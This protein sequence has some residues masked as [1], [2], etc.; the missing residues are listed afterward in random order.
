MLSQK[1]F[2]SNLKRMLVGLR[3]DPRSN[4]CGRCYSTDTDN[5]EKRWKIYTRTGDKG[6][7]SLFTGE[8]RAKDDI[9]F[10]ALGTTDE[11]SSALGLA[12]YYC[13]QAHNGLHESLEEAQCRLQEIG[14][15]IATPRTDAP[16]AHL[17]RWLGQFKP[18]HGS[19]H[20]PTC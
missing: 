11:L 15:N 18:A 7:S 17:R 13:K 16:D 12:V 4:I 1:L 20:L 10:E 9:V 5:N 8:R 2:T 19:Q 6:T 3:V 14:S